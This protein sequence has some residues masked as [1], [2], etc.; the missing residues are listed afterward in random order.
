M[1]SLT[2]AWHVRYIL[3]LLLGLLLAGNAAAL[4]THD[5]QGKELPSL[6]PMLEK[7]TPAVVNIATTG[8]VRVQGNPLLDDPFFRRFF[9][10]PEVPRERRTQ[11]LGL[12]LIH[13]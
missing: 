2:T 9:D 5:S 7:V 3:F 12:S 11:S 10:M 4:P 1:R 13:I 8:T 6:A